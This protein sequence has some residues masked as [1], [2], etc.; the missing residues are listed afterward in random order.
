M[1]Q[2]DWLS[3]AHHTHEWQQAMN[4]LVR[5]GN[6]A[7]IFMM[8]PARFTHHKIQPWPYGVHWQPHKQAEL[9][10]A[11]N[12]AN[13]SQRRS[14]KM[15][16]SAIGSSGTFRS[17]RTQLPSGPRQARPSY[18]KELARSEYVLSPDG[19]RPDCYRHYEALILGAIPIVSKRVYW[20]P[21]ALVLD[22][23]N[24]GQFRNLTA[25][26]DN[27]PA[28]TRPPAAAAFV[29][30]WALKLRAA[31]CSAGRAASCHALWDV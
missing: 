9:S 8:N 29:H 23:Y 15:F 5:N 21:G 26:Q 17:H 3:L 18:L 19:D 24:P 11:V 16:L 25:F 1:R 28:Y 4:A 14:R 31:E 12:A 7:T 2:S 20:L 30:Y 13:T 22:P 27:L 6:V 10:A